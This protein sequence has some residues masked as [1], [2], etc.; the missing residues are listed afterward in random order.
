[1]AIVTTIDRESWRDYLSLSKPR[2]VI[3]HIFTAAAA[4]FLAAGGLPDSKLLFYT[5]LGGGLVAAASNVINCYID[6]D[7]D[8]GMV[9]T[10]QRPLPAGRLHPYNALL[11]GSLAGMAGLFILSY[12]VSLLTALLA[13]SALSYYIL[14][15][16]LWLKRRTCWSSIVGSGAGAFPPLIGW[17]AITGQISIIPLLLFGIIALWT[18]PHFWSLGIFRQIEYELAGIRVIPR[19]HVRLW[20]VLF[21]IL[22]ISLSILVGFL[23][24]LGLIYRVIAPILGTG[25]L[26]LSLRLFKTDSNKPARQLYFYSILYLLITLVQIRF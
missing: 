1:M 4:M 25:L 14:I 10:C 24:G 23:T 20:I 6:R 26:F 13:F 7:I 11:V 3:L 2:V 9:R 15:Y 18:P 5:L 19:K 17:V 21:S 12:Y 16:T 8:G 22:L